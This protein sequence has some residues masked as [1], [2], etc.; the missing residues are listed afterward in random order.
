MNEAYRK[1]DFSEGHGGFP[2]TECIETPVQRTFINGL[3]AATVDADHDPHSSGATTHTDRK[4]VEGSPTVFI[5]FFEAA[6]TTDP[7][8]CGDTCG[9]GSPDTFIGDGS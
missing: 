9:I 1:T 6:R 7:I 5:E 3:L 8:E 4:I 2:P